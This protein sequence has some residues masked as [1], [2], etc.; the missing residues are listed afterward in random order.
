MYG[1]DNGVKC[2]KEY[3]HQK[4]SIFVKIIIT[5]FVV[6]SIYI[7][8]TVF[9]PA[10]LPVPDYQLVIDHNEDVR[11]LAT[12]LQDQGIIKNR[13]AFLLVL[14]LTH[15]DRKVT[16]GLYILKEPISIW[17]LIKRITNGHPDQISVT[18]IDGWTTTDVRTYVDNLTDIKHLS[19]NMTDDELRSTLKIDAPSLEG[20][21]Y[22]ETYFIA[23]NQTDLEVYQQA[24][25][26]MQEKLY[27]LYTTRT[28]NTFY[29]SPYQLLIMASLIQKETSKVDDMYLIST[30]FNNRLRAGM[31]LQDDPAVFYGLRDQKRVT[32]KD[33]QID[34]PYNTY[35]HAG[36]PPTP[37]CIPSFAALTAASKPLNQPDL[38]YFVATG[39]GET[40]FSA[41][42][43]QHLEAVNHYTKKEE[44]K[45]EAVKRADE[46]YHETIFNK[47]EHHET[48]K[49]PS[50]PEG[51]HHEHKQSHVV[52]SNQ[53]KD[54]DSDVW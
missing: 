3:K 25:R 22:P 40:H 46:K 4:T 36:L 42:Y 9:F 11:T 16:A 35:L 29:N 44:V 6:G 7:G 1:C 47:P 48:I 34:T 10:N 27:V 8:D 17:N 41:T 54:L 32:R 19:T 12:S 38:R 51:H 20:V 13:R 21:F 33:F 39:R 30:V 53:I 14:R 37:I 15:A 18:I 50:T 45:K 49:Q 5:L 31:K 52:G 28:S 43:D 23:P 2:M 24:Y 26:L